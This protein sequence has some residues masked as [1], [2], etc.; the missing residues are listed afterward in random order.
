M[1]KKSLTLLL[2]ITLLAFMGYGCDTGSSS[3]SGGIITIENHGRV[4][5]RTSATKLYYPNTISGTTGASTMSSGYTG[6]LDDIEWL[7]KKVAEA[8]FVVLAFTPANTLGMVSQWR[9]AHKNCVDELIS[10]NS[11]HSVLRGKIDTGKLNISG[12]SKGGG[13][14]LW[15][16]A[17]LTSKVKTTVPFAP[18]EEGFADSAL[19]TI[20]AATFIQAGAGDTLATN[21]MTRGE[22]SG[23]GNISKKYVEY[24]GYTHMAWANATGS[25]ATRIADDMVAWLKY[26]MNGDTSQYNTIANQ[27]GTTRFEWEDLGSGSSSSSST[28]SSSGGGCN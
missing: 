6:T 19:R 13:G 2:A 26:Y 28:S 11:T 20:T 4:G 21:Y 5:S 1:M 17:Q 12:H 7:S 15:A 25:T 18:Y 22:Y 8:G 14:S 9:D 16:S 10:I 3:S 27:S 24:T 23:L